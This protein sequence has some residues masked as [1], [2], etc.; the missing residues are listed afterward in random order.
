VGSTGTII[1]ISYGMWP[2]ASADAVRG[3]SAK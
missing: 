2:I 3:M 1:P